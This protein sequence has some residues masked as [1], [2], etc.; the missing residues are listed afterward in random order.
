[1]C[2]LISKLCVNKWEIDGL[3]RA[4]SHTIRKYQHMTLNTFLDKL[5]SLNPTYFQ[6]LLLIGATIAVFSNSLDHQ[7]LTS[8]DDYNY[9]VRNPDVYG[10]TFE[11]LRAA[12]TKFYVGNYAPLHIVSYMFDYTLWGMNPVG[13]V[14]ANIVL[15]AMNGLLFYWLVVKLTQNNR[16]AFFS[17]LI[18][19]LHPIQVES[20]AWIS[21]RKNLLAMFFFL[22][23]LLSYIYYR[24]NEARNGYIYYLVAILTFICALLTKS[25]TVVLPLV[26]VLYDIC[27]APR[28]YRRQWVVDKIPFFIAA[29][30]IA[31][32]TLK[33]QAYN[34]GGGIVNYPDESAY[35]IFLTMLTVFARYAGKLIW[36]TNLSIY[37]YIPIKTGIDVAV[38]LSG[39]FVSLICT[40]LFYLFRKDKAMF[41]WAALIPVGILPVSQLIPLSTLM[42]D[43]YLYFPLLGFAVLFTS[44][45]MLCIDR[46]PFRA[47][48]AGT[49]LMCL[50]LLPLPV[51]SWQ[52]SHVWFDSISLWSDALNKYPSFVTYA[53]MGNALYRANKINEAV[54]MYEKSLRLE[55]TCEEALRS[56]GAIYLNRGENNK[57][58]YYIKLF[59]ENYPDNAF[60]HKM[61]DIVNKQITMQANA[62]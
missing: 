56:L 28:Q 48:W 16:L 38:A 4:E 35:D 45:A 55:P 17:S 19:L 58:L 43:R 11:H 31:L 9:V 10:F 34:A 27:F 2:F 47:K 40:G 49:V 7:F 50:M 41:F 26:L 12:F 62:T 29:I 23:S 24:V 3:G 30:V 52:R 36:P 37:Y 5:R 54:K 22:I 51:L 39:I 14:S 57:A 13:Y 44:G 8:W 15:H 33:S 46:L 53:G 32:M 1:M 61:L 60:A 42:N 18:F 20:V 6:V 59:V 21:Q 25:V